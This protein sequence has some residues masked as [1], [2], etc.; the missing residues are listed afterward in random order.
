MSYMSYSKA[1]GLAI[2]EEM[3]RDENVFCLGLDLQ[4][5]G[6]AFGVTTGLCEEFGEKRIVNMPIAEAGYTGVAVGA[7]ATGLRPI[8]E[9]QFGDWVTIA[10]DQLVN[11]AANMRYMSGGALSV[12]MVMWWPTR[13]GSAI[14]FAASSLER[15]TKHDKNPAAH[16]LRPLLR[17]LRGAAAH[18]GYRAGFLLV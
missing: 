6:G 7:A 8:V 9:L 17:L 12:P 4:Y 11:Q 2:A 10:S 18:R 5:Y 13:A 3:R 14:S 16:L 15:R 1:L